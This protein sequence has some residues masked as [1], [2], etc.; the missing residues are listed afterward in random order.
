MKKSRKKSDH[1]V[2]GQ[3]TIEVPRA[4][5]R[6]IDGNLFEVFPPLTDEEMI[7]WS[8]QKIMQLEN[9]RSTLPAMLSTEDD[10]DAIE[11]LDKYEELEKI[12]EKEERK[13]QR[14]E[15]RITKLKKLKDAYRKRV[16]YLEKRLDTQES[17]EES[18][19]K[20]KRLGL[21]SRRLFRTNLSTRNIETLTNLNVEQEIQQH[22]PIVLA[23]LES[24]YKRM[25]KKNKAYLSKRQRFLGC[26]ELLN[27]ANNNNYIGRMWNLVSKTAYLRTHSKTML[28]YF[29]NV[30]ACG[31][32]T[33][34]LKEIK[35]LPSLDDT[36]PIHGACIIILDNCQN[37]GK[38]IYLD[39][40]DN[41]VDVKVVTAFVT[42]Y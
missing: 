15:A 33:N 19:K 21:I 9:I 13:N 12:I 26:L 32:Y 22:D 2:A 36:I 4:R 40:V 41:K 7:G 11:I 28:S 5:K 38:K 3:A 25:H 31:S 16:Q 37:D 8:T 17:L 14:Q 18:I 39:R 20:A 27:K 1:L 23:F 6:K 35:E 42:L 34:I 10:E 30:G 29:S 24:R